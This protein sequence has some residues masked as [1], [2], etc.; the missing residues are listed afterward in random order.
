MDGYWEGLLSNIELGHRVF[1]V[2]LVQCVY[3]IYT[4][5]KD[6]T[7]WTFERAYHIKYHLKN[8]NENNFKYQS[9]Y[10]LYNGI[11]Y[12][13]ETGHQK[14]ILLMTFKIKHTLS[15][16]APMVFKFLELVSNFIEASK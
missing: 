3:S 15:V 8:K 16:H 13:K 5:S 11:H 1:K 6:S 4:L 9:V 7:T 2:L 12:F 10:V 14:N